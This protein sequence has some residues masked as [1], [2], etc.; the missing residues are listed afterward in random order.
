M[1]AMSQHK[2]AYFTVAML[3][4][5]PKSGRGTS[6]DAGAL[7]CV[8]ADFDFNTGNNAHAK[9]ALPKVVGELDDFLLEIGM[10]PPTFR[11]NSGNG[12]H[13]YWRL[14]EPLIFSDDAARAK[15]AALLK[16]FQRTIIKLAKEKR[17]WE[18][19]NTADLA[20]VLRY[21]G[22]KNHKT[23]PPKNVEII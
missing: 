4:N 1:I 11:V 3:K 5:P 7:S 19:D 23:N 9:S 6:K 17:G 16:N 8:H 15:G 18:F 22:T 21:P 10:M 20:R 14:A 12:M 2:D 13:A